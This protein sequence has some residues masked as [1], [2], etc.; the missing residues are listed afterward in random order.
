MVT[1]NKPAA[2]TPNWYRAITDNWTEIEQRLLDKNAMTAKGDLFAAPEA[3][4]LSVL[5]VGAN[6]TVLLADSTQ[7]LGVRWADLNGTGYI[8][9]Q[10]ARA[11]TST[12]TNSTSYVDMD[13]MSVSITVGASEKVLVLFNANIE[14][15][16]N[17][18]ALS[19]LRDSTEI[20]Y[21]TVGSTTNPWGSP[22]SKFIIDQPGSG[23]F[24]Y[25]I[26]WKV[27]SNSS[28]QDLQPYSANGDRYIAAVV[29]PG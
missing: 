22:A 20:D 18:C 16:N 13:S 27:F 21:T 2:G 24:T 19:L 26:Q 25:K 23:T 9:I 11:T 6:N 17:H 1:M 29:L 8:D 10:T 3:K 4:A 12:S 14:G 5:P 28:S 7:A 15:G